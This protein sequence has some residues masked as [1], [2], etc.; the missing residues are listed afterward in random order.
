MAS[1]AEHS[2]EVV[3]MVDYLRE[4]IAEFDQTIT[5]MQGRRSALAA[6]LAVIEAGTDPDL[7]AAAQD[8]AERVAENRPYEDAMS[9]DELIRA[10]RTRIHD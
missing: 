4:T 2:E 10:A 3:G 1:R 7:A 8:Y 6:R 9:A 5:E